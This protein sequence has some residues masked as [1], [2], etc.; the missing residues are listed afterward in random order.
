MSDDEKYAFS[1]PQ[2]QGLS[3]EM[4][5]ELREIMTQTELSY[6]SNETQEKESFPFQDGLGLEG[7]ALE[8]FKR[9]R[10]AFH[11]R[12][13][14]RRKKEFVDRLNLCY[15]RVANENKRLKRDHALLKEHVGR[16]AQLVERARAGGLIGVSGRARSLSTFVPNIPVQSLGMFEPSPLPALGIPGTVAR[17]PIAAAISTQHQQQDL[18][19]AIVRHQ[20]T[21]SL[22]ASNLGS[23][24]LPLTAGS[25]PGRGLG[26]GLEVERVMSRPLLNPLAIAQLEAVQMQR[27]AATIELYRQNQE[28]QYLAALLQQEQALAR[29]QMPRSLQVQPT[30]R[31]I[32]SPLGRITSTPP[33]LPRT[34]PNRGKDGDT[35]RAR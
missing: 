2:K 11:S 7:E 30:L 5:R 33:R 9:K 20:Q 25:L 32:G 12:K 19:S 6:G 1:V 29:P 18:M 21:Q 14:R 22:L 17:A 13:K 8:E 31:V 16:A 15:E 10:N 3:L 35:K 27:D 28:S 34:Q 26:L 23:D 4:T 24:P